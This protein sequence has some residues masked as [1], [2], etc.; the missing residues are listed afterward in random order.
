LHLRRGGVCED[1]AMD[2]DNMSGI[3]QHDERMHWR[4]PMLGGEVTF[5]YCRRLVEGMPC[6]RIVRCWKPIFDIQDFLDSHYDRDELAAIWNRPRP[7]KVVQLSELIARATQSAGAAASRSACA[8]DCEPMHD[9][10]T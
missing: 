2:K 8:S 1:V 5:R 3:E 6:A 4:C 7:D 10:E 9:E